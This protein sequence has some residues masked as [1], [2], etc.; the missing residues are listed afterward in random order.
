M[1]NTAGQLCILGDFNARPGRQ[2]ATT[3]EWPHAARAPRHGETTCNTPGKRLLKLCADHGL[4]IISSQCAHCSGPTFQ[5]NGTN[6]TLTRSHIDFILAST[7]AA[8]DLPQAHRI[9]HSDQWAIPCHSDHCPIVAPLLPPT[10][11]PRE[12][13]RTMARP[14]LERL[15]EEQPA[16]AYQACFAEALQPWKNM[17]HQGA[18]LPEPS[19]V[20]QA[21]QFLTDVINHATQWALGLRYIVTGR[22]ITRRWRR[23]GT[24]QLL[25]QRRTAAAILKRHNTT[26]NAARL[27][28]LR[29]RTSEALKADWHTHQQQKSTK[30]KQLFRARAAPKRMH[31]L[32]KS[33]SKVQGER[34]P[35]AV[36]RHPHTGDIQEEPAD[37][38][39]AYASFLHDLGS[40]NAI[41][42]KRARADN[43]QAAVEAIAAAN[44]LEAAADP[45]ITHD[46][47][48][49][50]LRRMKHGKAPGLDGIPAELLQASG[51]AGL[52]M[53]TELLNAVFQTG[54]L[55]STWRIGSI[56]PVFKKGDR[57][58][59]GNYRP[60]TLL[61]T[62][63]KLYAA[64]LDSRLRH[65]L[66]DHA[67]QYGFCK[68]RG[69]AES[70]FNLIAAIEKAFE[71]GKKLYMV[72][73]DV[74]KA[75]DEVCRAIMLVN[76]HNRG[77]Q[78]KLWFAVKALYARTSAVVS[79]GNAQS[80][81]FDIQKGVAQGCPLSPKLFNTYTMDMLEAL[82]AIAPV[83]G[84]E[85]PGSAPGCNTSKQSAGSM[86]ADDCKAISLDEHGIVEVVETLQQAVDSKNMDTAPEKS[87]FIRFQRQR[88][89]AGEDMP[90]LT[91]GHQE[92]AGTEVLKD[93]G[94]HLQYNLDWAPHISKVTQSGNNSLFAYADTLLTQGLP[95]GVKRLVIKTHILPKMRYGMETWY[96][97]TA[98]AR[99]AFKEAEVVL[100]KTLWYSLGVSKRR[101]TSMLIPCLDSDVLH[102]DLGIPTLDTENQAA[103]IRFA[104]KHD[105]SGMFATRDPDALPASAHIASI[106]RARRRVAGALA[107]ADV[108]AAELEVAPHRRPSNKEITASLHTQY[109][110]RCLRKKV[111]NAPEPDPIRRHGRTL[112]RRGRFD[113]DRAPGRTQFAQMAYEMVFRDRLGTV[114]LQQQPP[115]LSYMA[116]LDAKSLPDARAIAAIRSGHLLDELYEQPGQDDQAQPTFCSTVAIVHGACSACGRALVHYPPGQDCALEERPWL[117]ILHRILD[118]DAHAT[119][120]GPNHR[121]AAWVHFC[122]AIREV[123]AP[124][125][126][127]AQFVAGMLHGLN[128]LQQSIGA[129]EQFLRFLLCPTHTGA[130]PAP[131]RDMLI[132]LT[133]ALI[134]GDSD[135]VT[136]A[137]APAEGVAADAPSE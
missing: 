75:F 12:E 123:A 129:R 115:C 113:G 86:F 24:A 43:A 42:D 117:R 57:A 63:D 15:R 110:L 125:P 89:P 93:L 99:V 118:C 38:A 114:K 10:A 58:Q 104:Y 28:T 35:P 64:V 102:A 55:P 137:D 39:G 25:K 11:N 37:V 96:A 7:A 65:A 128:Q 44:P 133:A 81:P 71:Q 109:M 60:I 90:S 72:S 20:D 16:Q 27:E 135:P 94:L 116:Y 18:Q 130:P 120:K 22:K 107:D 52:T 4:Q 68:G 33:T 124:H 79:C 67:E 131:L 100:N 103:K 13:R 112:R 31:A 54:T 105:P 132:R 14:R 127:Y 8:T 50:C 97:N 74:R 88:A 98:Q 122:D 19:R 92:I 56:T 6:G 91:V 21:S 136:L 17:L 30:I 73:L 23:R 134:R 3:R 80:D 85:I 119:P 62:L 87:T 46:E 49:S 45:P 36:L 53:I 106:E 40:D 111:P 126:Q 121:P 77:V 51:L 95:I 101:E 41:G 47:V 84:A 29:Q 69:T 26:E 66:P 61:R 78:G 1:R 76:L 2:R 32:I 83:H 108:Q 70:H 9:P 82:D 48:A 34:T 5:R 59:C